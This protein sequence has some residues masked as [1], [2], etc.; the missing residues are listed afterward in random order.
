MPVASTVTWWNWR[1]VCLAIAAR[2]EVGVG[3]H[4]DNDGGQ[5]QVSRGRGAGEPVK[6]PFERLGFPNAGR[7]DDDAVR[8]QGGCVETHGACCLVNADRNVEVTHGRGGLSLRRSR[9]LLSLGSMHA[10][11]AG[12]PLGTSSW[13]R[14]VVLAPGR[15]EAPAVGEENARDENPGAGREG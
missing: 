7:T 10:L 6:D 14:V 9:A 12:W 8:A 5:M 1:P 15:V 2:V 13:S 11:G 3:L 4:V